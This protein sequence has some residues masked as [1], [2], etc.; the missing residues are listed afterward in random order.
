MEMTKEQL[1]RCARNLLKTM[2]EQGLETFE[3]LRS[4]VGEVFDPKADDGYHG[5]E[6]VSVEAQMGALILRYVRRSG[7]VPILLKVTPSSAKMM[8]TCTEELEGFEV[9]DEEPGY[10]Q[11]MDGRFASYDEARARLE[12]LAHRG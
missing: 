10:G 1:A 2:K 3:G 11:L 6:Y 12:R 8:L 5:E 7:Q 9:F 4:A